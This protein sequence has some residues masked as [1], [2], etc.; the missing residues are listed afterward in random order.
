MREKLKFTL[1]RERTRSEEERK[2]IG[3]I[4]LM[5]TFMLQ[6]PHKPN[7]KPRYGMTLITSRISWNSWKADN[8]QERLVKAQMALL[9]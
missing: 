7:G 1:A 9:G 5:L 4:Q 6:N 8:Q 3:M 2:D